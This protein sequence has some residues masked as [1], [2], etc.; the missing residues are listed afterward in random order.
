MSPTAQTLLL[1]GALFYMA[2][3]AARAALSDA[4][5]TQSVRQVISAHPDLGTQIH[6]RIRQPQGLD[7]RQQRHSHL[8]H[9]Q[10]LESCGALVCPNLDLLGSE[11]PKD[12]TQCRGP[13]RHTGALATRKWV[14]VKR[15]RAASLLLR[16][17]ITPLA[18][19]GRDE[20]LA[21]VVAFLASD[22]SSFMSGSE[23]FVDGGLAQVWGR[24]AVSP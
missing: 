2:L 5:I 14:R 10:R 12:S 13:W 23:V 7:C 9:I 15:S 8:E 4:S 22:D 19:T 18:R 11:G 24:A 16:P 21:K 20:E 1:T 17:S 3:P 6:V